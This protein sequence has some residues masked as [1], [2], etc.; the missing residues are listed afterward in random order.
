VAVLAHGLALLGA[1]PLALGEPREER[2]AVGRGVDLGRVDPL[3]E[4]S[5]L[6]VDLPAADPER[7][8]RFRVSRDPEEAA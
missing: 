5:R 6:L 7:A 1:A 2:V 4:P 3:G 8:V